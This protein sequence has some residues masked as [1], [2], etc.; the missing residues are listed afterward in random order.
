M[1]A[2]V[3]E[4]VTRHGTAAESVNC[5]AFTGTPKTA[6]FILS[7]EY[8]L[9]MSPPPTQPA[10]QPASTLTLPHTESTSAR[11]HDA[12]HK[13]THQAWLAR[14]HTTMHAHVYTPHPPPTT[15][16]THAATH[17]VW[18]SAQ[19]TY[20]CAH[21]AANDACAKRWRQPAR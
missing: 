7:S 11:A 21:A 4:T 9:H 10:S 13:R 17:A 2:S 6:D 12:A 16:L 3:D 1:V 19:S 14:A 5:T 18:Q 15:R 20:A 8:F